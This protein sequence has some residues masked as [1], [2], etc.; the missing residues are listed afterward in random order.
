MKLKLTFG[1]IALSVMTLAASAAQVTLTGVEGANNGTDYVAPY[2]L[3]ID[4]VPY[5]ATCYDFF[6]SVNLNQTWTADELSLTQAVAYGK[7]GG[8]PG[9][10]AGYQEVA[11]LSTLNTNGSAQQQ[12]DLQQDIW[13][14]F[15][16]GT[17]AVTPGM[18]AF[19]VEEQSV[20]P[21]FDFDSVTFIE[22]DPAGVQDFVVDMSSA[23]EPASMFMLVSGLL[24]TAGGFRRRR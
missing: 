14:V 4:G 19:L 16:P 2:Y 8:Q 10:L 23:P 21:G 12:V 24:I 1:G 13:N 20:S 7:F 6:D 17:F 18:A 5:D 9:S 22:S 15:D 11:V 3:T